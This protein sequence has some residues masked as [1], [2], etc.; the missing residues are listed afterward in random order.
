M[1]ITMV[2][3]IHSQLHSHTHTNPDRFKPNL[4]F[5]CDV[6]EEVLSLCN[7]KTSLFFTPTL[8]CSLRVNW[9]F[10]SLHCR[11]ALLPPP[12]NYCFIT[13]TALLS[14]TSVVDMW[15]LTAV[16]A[17]TAISLITF[18]HVAEI[19]VQCPDYILCCAYAKKDK[20]D[21]YSYPRKCL[22]PRWLIVKWT[23]TV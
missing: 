13:S 18:F 19:Q 20:I 2:N 23:Y 16:T 4:C 14:S 17:K 3:Y 11:H 8:Q 22:W 6:S 21:L 1:S 15:S 7:T 5:F 12:P 10:P 9:N